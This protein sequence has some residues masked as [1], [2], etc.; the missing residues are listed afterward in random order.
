MKQGER[1]DFIARK[2][3]IERMIEQCNYNKDTL[4]ATLGDEELERII[5]KFTDS[6]ELLEKEIQDMP[7]HHEYQG[8][9]YLR[10][11]YTEPMQVI[12][13]VNGKIIMRE[14]LITWSIY[15]PGGEY[16]G[17]S[18]FVYKDNELKQLFKR[19]DGYPM[20]EHELKAQAS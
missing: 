19:E 6:V 4:I 9:F 17:M 14:D 8:T 2:E 12:E 3:R 13:V 1:K 7:V 18:R 16:Y 20:Y 15:Y 10:K 5:E 11:P